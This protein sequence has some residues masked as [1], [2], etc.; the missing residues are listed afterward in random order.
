MPILTVDDIKD[1]LKIEDPINNEALTD[2]I[3]AVEEGLNFSCGYTAE[4][5][6]T[7]SGRASGGLLELSKRP[8]TSLTSLTGERYGALTVANFRLSRVGIQAK[9]GYTLEDDYYT[10]VYV[11]GRATVPEGIKQG[12]RII[13]KHQWSELRRG[14]TRRPNEDTA[15]IPGFG[16]AVPRM[17][18]EVLTP[19]LE[20]PASG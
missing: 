2:L 7:E 16:F 1:A 20:G 15:Q 13:L 14:P 8:A 19:W 12:A 17:A 4:T 5:T 3:A 11:V 10:T 6:I 9:Y 18:A